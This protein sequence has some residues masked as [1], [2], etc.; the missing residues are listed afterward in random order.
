M[1]S[2]I[3]VNTLKNTS[4]TI[5]ISIDDLNTIQDTCIYHFDNVSSMVSSTYLQVGMTVQTLGY[6]TSGDGGGNFYEIV[7]SST[8]TVDGGSFIDLSGISGQAEGIFPTGFVNVRQF[9]ATGD[10]VTNDL[11]FINNATSYGDLVFFPKGVYYVDNGSGAS[12]NFANKGTG[13]YVSE[14]N[15]L[16]R[17]GVTCF[18][19][20]PSTVILLERRSNSFIALLDPSA[21]SL[22]EEKVS[23]CVWKDMKIDGDYDGTG[24]DTTNSYGFFGASNNSEFTN[25]EMTNFDSDAFDFAG[26]RGHSMYNTVQNCSITNC[27]RHGISLIEASHNTIKENNFETIV[28]GGIR[29][30]PD[31]EQQEIKYN[32]LLR[33]TFEADVGVPITGNHFGTSAGRDNSVNNYVVSNTI[34]GHAG[35]VGIFFDDFKEINVVRNTVF[36][37]EKAID[38]SNCEGSYIDENIIYMADGA[39]SGIEADNSS[40]LRTKISRNRI[41]SIGASPE[42]TGISSASP[43]N[44]EI[45]FNYIE[46]AGRDGIFCSGTDSIKIIGN[47]IN[48]ANAINASG[49]NAGIYIDNSGISPSRCIVSL[50]LV[51][52]EKGTTTLYRGIHLRGTYTASV[53]GSNIVQDNSNTAFTG[54]TGFTDAGGNVS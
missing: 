21:T 11:S 29:L 27:G 35:G 16:A 13:N 49:N 32:S 53:Y 20:G 31:Q 15:L 39:V 51:N 45:S 9:G 25:L 44:L 41:V 10:G 30:E 26:S 28:S 6:Y 14:R 43:D 46:N 34:K 37:D 7:A 36:S 40:L 54:F 8:G 47:E 22:T 2:E 50:N 12:T 17:T 24:P 5:E 48:G 18:G 4:E 42:H 1:T 38:L 52:D 19:E 33:N 23:G 3:R